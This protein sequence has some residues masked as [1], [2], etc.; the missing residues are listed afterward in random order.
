MSP[1]DSD[2]YVLQV[3]LND[4]AVSL[5]SRRADRTAVSNFIVEPE[6]VVVFLC[7]KKDSNT[8]PHY[9]AAGGF[10]DKSISLCYMRDEKYSCI[11]VVKEILIDT[12]VSPVLR[13][14]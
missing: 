3:G 7:C 9:Y 12:A 2:I 13:R 14:L 6:V 5:C 4:T 1:A 10:E 8:Q 11:P